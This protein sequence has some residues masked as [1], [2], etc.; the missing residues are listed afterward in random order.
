MKAEASAEMEAWRER[1]G[2]A[3][4]ALEAGAPLTVEAIADMERR[5]LTA[6]IPVD[7]PCCRCK[8][9]RVRRRSMRVLDKQRRPAGAE[10]AASEEQEG[11]LSPMASRSAHAANI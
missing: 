2:V 3:I 7:N 6:A 9:T 11:R 10:G 8:L 5:W 4:D 1:I